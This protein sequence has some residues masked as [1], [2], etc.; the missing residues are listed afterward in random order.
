MVFFCCCCLS[1]EIKWTKKSEANERWRKRTTEKR[2]RE[3]EKRLKRINFIIKHIVLFFYSFL[4]VLL[5]FLFC[6]SVSLSLSLV[7]LLS[8]SL[9]VIFVRWFLHVSSSQHFSFIWFIVANEII[10][11][12]VCAFLDKMKSALSFVVLCWFYFHFS[13]LSSGFSLFLFPY[14]GIESF[15]WIFIRFIW[16]CYIKQ[17]LWAFFLSINS[18]VDVAKFIWKYFIYFDWVCE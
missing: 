11:F 4:F 1:V 6:V 14:R 15:R 5:S 16:L 10:D 18:Y 13:I 7:L 9:C 17:L 3:N 8:H 2:V 12:C